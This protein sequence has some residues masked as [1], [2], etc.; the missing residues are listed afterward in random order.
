MVDVTW[1]TLHVGSVELS[2]HHWHLDLYLDASV[3][4]PSKQAPPLAR[5]EGVR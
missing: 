5:L 1:L 2:L 3:D 4:A